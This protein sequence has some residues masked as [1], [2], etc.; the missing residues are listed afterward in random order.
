MNTAKIRLAGHLTLVAAVGVG[1]GYG[2]ARTVHM[3]QIVEIGS[4][5]CGVPTSG[6][7]F[8]FPLETIV[9]AAGGLSFGIGPIEVP[10]RGGPI[11]LRFEPAIDHEARDLRLVDDTLY[12]PT[13]FGRERRS[14]TRITLHCRE[15][16]IGS[17]RYQDG[18]RESATFNVLRAS[19]AVISGRSGGGACDHRPAADPDDRLAARQFS[20]NLSSRMRNVPSRSDMLSGRGARCRDGANWHFLHLG[21]LVAGDIPPA[22]R[23]LFHARVSAAGRPAW[24]MTARHHHR[25]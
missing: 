22:Q 3:P 17:V 13:A 16:V 5:A 24:R 4:T 1:G 9:Q 25:R 21:R 18:R 2:W 23:D 19:A 12:L 7:R 10:E 6:P 14:P 15:G 11:R 20:W 8:G